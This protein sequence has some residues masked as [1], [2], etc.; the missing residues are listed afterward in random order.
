MLLFVGD[1]IPVEQL[2]R[3]PLRLSCCSHELAPSF[4]LHNAVFHLQQQRQTVPLVQ[5]AA[6]KES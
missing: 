3:I 2:L 1:P 6:G 4:H 5:P